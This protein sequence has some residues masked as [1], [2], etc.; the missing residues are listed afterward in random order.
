MKNKSN[1]S[2][3]SGIGFTG[4]LTILF[5]GLKLTGY[6]TW[7]WWW[8]LSPIWITFL[9]VMVIVMVAIWASTR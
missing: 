8:V 4:L 5:I 6:I 1:T 7:S 9:I 2:S 3:S